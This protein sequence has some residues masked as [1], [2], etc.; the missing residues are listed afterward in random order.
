[1]PLPMPAMT[2]CSSSSATASTHA[3]QRP[4]GL[5][6]ARATAAPRPANHAPEKS[7][8]SQ[9]RDQPLAACS[10]HHHHLA[11]LLDPLDDAPSAYDSDSSAGSRKRRRLASDTPPT[12][13]DEVQYWDYSRQ[14][15]PHPERLSKWIT[16]S[17]IMDTTSTAGPGVAP[18]AADRA[19]C[20]QEDWEDLKELFAKAAEIY[21]SESPDPPARRCDAPRCVC[22]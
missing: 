14:C 19:T 4:R 16:R 1:M 13:D 9:K 22:C 11:D 15:S 7:H 2:C 8:P 10:H 18:P 20:D 21:E 3:P 17:K 6:R 5:W 12:S